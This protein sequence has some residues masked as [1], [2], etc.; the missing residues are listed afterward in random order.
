[1]TGRS[2]WVGFYSKKSDIAKSMTI[3]TY[4]ENATWKRKALGE[5]F[6]PQ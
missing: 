5:N 3:F 6:S 1:M 2:Q 4:N